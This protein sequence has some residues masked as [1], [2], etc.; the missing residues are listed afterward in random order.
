MRWLERRSH[1]TLCALHRVEICRQCCTVVKFKRISESP[2]TE[3]VNV[4]AP[5]R[6]TEYHGKLTNLNVDDGMGLL[7]ARSCRKCF[8]QRVVSLSQRSHLNNSA[9]CCTLLVQ[10]FINSVTGECE[11]LLNSPTIM[12]AFFHST[13]RRMCE[14]RSSTCRTQATIVCTVLVTRRIWRHGL[15]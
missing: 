9:S 15:Y 10:P 12:F 5:A 7:I 8:T 6:C 2:F 11:A 4:T 3:F 1:M 14:R 13:Q